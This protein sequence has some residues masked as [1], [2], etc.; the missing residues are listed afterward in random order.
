MPWEG[1]SAKVI[2]ARAGRFVKRRHIE[3]TEAFFQ[4][5]GGKA[6]VFARF[7]PVVRTFAPFVAG[8]GKMPPRRFWCFNLAGAI[9]WTA[10]FVTA[11]Y[12]FGSLPWVEGNLTLVVLLIVF[13]SV[14]PLTGQ[15]L[16]F[17]V[18]DRCSE[19]V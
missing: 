2:A 5:H 6:L 14:V 7:L 1:C 11:G 17:T 3:A 10:T 9:A 18:A 12:F 13:A 8:M 4:R 19:A 15:R 16:H